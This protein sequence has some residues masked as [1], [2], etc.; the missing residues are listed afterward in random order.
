M[1]FGQLPTQTPIDERGLEKRTGGARSPLILIKGVCGTPAVFRLSVDVS[2]GKV[3]DSCYSDD[4]S[5]PGSWR[6]HIV[7]GPCCD[8]G[9][10]GFRNLVAAGIHLRS[11]S[12]D[13]S[14]RI[15]NIVM[16][17]AVVGGGEPP[18]VDDHPKVS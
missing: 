4:L 2:C 6:G 9:D 1:K 17:I 5:A 16:I 13:C 7:T 11:G 12:H 8:G 18:Q 15:W 10:E 3:G 14:R